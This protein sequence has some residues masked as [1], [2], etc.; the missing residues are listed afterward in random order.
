MH[1]QSDQLFVFIYAIWNMGHLISENW[2]VCTD[3][4]ADLSV[5]CKKILSAGI[6]RSGQ[7]V[8]TQIRLLLWGAVWSGSTLFA[9]P[10]TFFDLI[11]HC[12]TT[13]SLSKDCCKYFRY[14]S[15]KNFTKLYAHDWKIPFHVTLFISAQTYPCINYFMLQRIADLLL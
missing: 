11:L 10:P 5:Y 1:L 7:I 3:A 14:F 6:E 12:K 13:L 8:Q 2:P 15:L 4:Q 9:I